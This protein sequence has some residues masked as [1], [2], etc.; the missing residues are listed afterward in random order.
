MTISGGTAPFTF[1][2]DNGAITEDIGG[3]AA[4]TYNVVVTD[5]N[6]C[7]ANTSA[8]ITNSPTATLSTTQVDETCSAANGSIDLTVTGGTGPFTFAWDNGAVTE[9]IGGLAANTYNVVVTD[10]N[11]CIANASATL[12]NAATATLSTTQIDPTC[13]A[14]NG[15]VDLTVT[16]GTAPFTFAWD[17]GA[18][19]E[20]IGALAANTYNVIVT[21]NNG[22]IANASVTL[23]NTGGPVAST[24]QVDET[25]SASNGSIDLTIVGGTAPFTFAW[26]NG[27][28][29]EDISG[30]A[31]N[32]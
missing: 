30:L 6:G 29:T 1:A 8:T 16:G 27:A 11:G 2:W 31:A 5:F 10:N 32:T 17:N 4:N 3:L 28:V 12:T 14:S 22:C 13:G 9:D 23:N 19:T 24:T 26:D 7:I 15:S 18:I 21:D 25:C 20:D